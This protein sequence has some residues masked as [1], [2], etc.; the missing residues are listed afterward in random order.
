MATKR[1]VERRKTFETTALDVLILN[2]IQEQ[3]FASVEDI[4]R[5]ID[6]HDYLVVMRRVHTLLANGWLNQ[7]RRN[8]QAVYSVK[9]NLKGL[10]RALTA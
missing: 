4:H 2:E 5:K 7:Q 9:G 3:G 10:A 1:K 6:H 8:S